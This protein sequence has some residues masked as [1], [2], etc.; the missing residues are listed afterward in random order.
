MCMVGQRGRNG[1]RERERAEL[2]EKKTM[3]KI[4]NYY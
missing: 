4:I 1:E 2:G 3:H